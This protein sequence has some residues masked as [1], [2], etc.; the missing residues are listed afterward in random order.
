MRACTTY[1]NCL[2]HVKA[3]F[4]VRACQSEEAPLSLSRLAFAYQKP[5]RLGGEQNQS[6]QRGYPPVDVDEWFDFMTVGDRE[7]SHPLQSPRQA[8]DLKLRS[9][10]AQSDSRPS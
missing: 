9:E 8:K 1:N 4:L 7:C 10:R 6:E 5:R 2:I 3:G